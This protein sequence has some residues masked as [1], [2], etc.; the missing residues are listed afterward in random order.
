MK[1]AHT[2]T[3]RLSQSSVTSGTTDAELAESAAQGDKL[4]FEL[5]MRRHNQL[6]FRTARSILNT[7]SET[8]DA[9]QEA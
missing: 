9:L 1:N 2:S 6:L 5:I 3:Q 7:D 4:A 8:E